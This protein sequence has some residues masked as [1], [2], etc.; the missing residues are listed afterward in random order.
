MNYLAFSGVTQIDNIFCQA[1]RYMLVKDELVD[2]IQDGEGEIIEGYLTYTK[3]RIKAKDEQ[4]QSTFMNPIPIQKKW[5]MR[6]FVIVHEFERI[7]YKAL[8]FYLFPYLVVFLSYTLY[9]KSD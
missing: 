2:S 5:Q 9:T 7:I 6:F 1:Q 8:Y 4:I 3:E